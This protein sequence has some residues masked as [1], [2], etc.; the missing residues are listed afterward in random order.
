MAPS[1]GARAPAAAPTSG[2][3]PADLRLFRGHAVCLHYLRTAQLPVRVK[4]APSNLP[5]NSCPGARGGVQEQQ[6]NADQSLPGEVCGVDWPA[7][8]GFPLRCSDLKELTVEGSLPAP[9]PHSA[10]CRKVFPGGGKAQWVQ[11]GPTHP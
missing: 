2:S 10:S 11:P 9:A 5:K 1:W 4:V 7:V 6:G 3:S 8:F